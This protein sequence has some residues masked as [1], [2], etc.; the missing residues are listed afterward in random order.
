MVG[1]LVESRGSLTVIVA[2]K[3][4]WVGSANTHVVVIKLES[5]NS[6]GSS[7]SAPG[8]YTQ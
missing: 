5:D 4:S 8:K 1:G 7:R 6:S 2:E 3:R